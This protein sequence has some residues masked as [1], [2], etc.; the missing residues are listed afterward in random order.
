MTDRAYLSQIL[1]ATCGSTSAANMADAS[2]GVVMAGLRAGL[3]D[4]NVSSRDPVR[5]A[6]AEAWI[7]TGRD[8]RRALG[9]ISIFERVWDASG[10]LGPKPIGAAPVRAG[11]GLPARASRRSAERPGGKE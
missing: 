4:G 5:T 7:S 2:M 8:S 6:A 1:S 3:A 9:V 11:P 10:R